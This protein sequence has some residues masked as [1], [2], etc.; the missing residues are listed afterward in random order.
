MRYHVIGDEF[1]VLGFALAGVTG[2]PVVSAE[3]AERAFDRV[4]DDPETGILVITERVADLI[5]PRVDE[6]IFSDRFPLVLEI[7]DRTG[8]LE[9]KPGIRELVRKAIGIQI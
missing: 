3:E 8:P 6:L 4:L 1:A 2:T 7:P 9:D 5:R